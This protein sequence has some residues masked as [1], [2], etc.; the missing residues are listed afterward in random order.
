MALVE[1][2]AEVDRRD[3]ALAA[4]AAL[5][6]RLQHVY[7]GLGV[8]IQVRLRHSLVV[9]QVARVF[10][11]ACNE[12]GDVSASHNNEPRTRTERLVTKSGAGLA[13]M[14]VI[15]GERLRRRMLKRYAESPAL[16]SSSWLSELRTTGAMNENDMYDYRATIYIWSLA[17]RLIQYAWEYQP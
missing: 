17:I 8:P 3:E 13:K 4:A 16:P 10:A 1:V 7:L 2:L 11:D 14:I 15:V 5:V 6:A 9:A 12:N